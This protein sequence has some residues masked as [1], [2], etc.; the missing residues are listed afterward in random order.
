MGADVNFDFAVG[1][2][3]DVGLFVARN[4]RTSPRREDRGAVCALLDEEG[5][6]DAN[7]AAIWLGLLLTLTDFLEANGVDGAVQ[8]FGMVTAVE[9]FADDVVVG[10]LLRP[11]H[12]AQSD[13]VRLKL[14]FLGNSI[15]DRFDR[16]AYM[17]SCDSAVRNDR[18]FVCGNGGRVAAVMRQNIRAGK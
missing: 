17:G 7:I 6:A 2:Q 14:S 8:T 9:M 10:H 3:L 12:V 18:T 15:H 5:N 11:H 1:S 16:D 4:D 13:L